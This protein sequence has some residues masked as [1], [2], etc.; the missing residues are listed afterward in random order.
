[1][2]YLKLTLAPTD[3]VIHPFDGFLADHGAVQR[4]AVLH[5]DVRA[6]DTTVLLYRLTG[7]TAALEADLDEQEYIRDHKVVDSRTEGAYAFVEVAAAERGGELVDLAHRHTLIIDTPLEYVDA[8]IR[9]TL[10][11]TPAN[12]RNALEAMPSH[13]DIS[14]ENGGPYVPA[15]QDLLT[16]VTDRQLEVFQTAVEEGYYDVPRRATHKDIADAP[17]C[18]PSTVD[19]HLRKVE[20][21]IIPQLVQQTQRSSR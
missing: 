1:M 19:E 5:I 4:E 20:S 10:V 12:L 3:R 21:H 2:K 17:D 6:D 18:S 15:D 7:D 8:G 16:P 14:I 11:G 9:A 13:I